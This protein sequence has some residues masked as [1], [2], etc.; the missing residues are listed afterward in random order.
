[1][2]SLQVHERVLAVLGGAATTAGM[3]CVLQLGGYRLARKHRVASKQET[4]VPDASLTLTPWVNVPLRP[5]SVMSG[6]LILSVV[7]KAL[8]YPDT[9]PVSKFLPFLSETGVWQT[10]VAIFMAS[11]Y[12]HYLTI[13]YLV[14]IGTPVEHG[15]DVKTMCIHGP[16]EFFKHPMYCAMMGCSFSA[17]LTNDSLWSLVPTAVFGAYLWGWVIPREE[18][19]MIDK[20]GSNYTNKKYGY[21]VM[22]KWLMGDN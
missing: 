15:Y 6:T 22:L 16:F 5:P 7:A 14:K 9:L 8:S 13:K 11:A 1:M 17:C 12:Q 4:V 2:S 10:G 3:I 18:K 19:Y 20:F 21:R